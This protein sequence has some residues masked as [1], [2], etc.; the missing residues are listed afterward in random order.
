M[1]KLIIEFLGTAFLVFIILSIGH[2]MAV[3]LTVALIAFIG[4]PI[5]GGHYNPVVSAVMAS[6]GTMSMS[7]LATYTLSQ[8]LGGFVGL[9]LSKRL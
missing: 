3:G 9:E 1:N 8:L 4:L 7:D 5:S 2:P 6:N